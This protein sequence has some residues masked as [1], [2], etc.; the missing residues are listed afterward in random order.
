M[1]SALFTMR[2]YDLI[3][4]A[5]ERRETLGYLTDLLEEMEE[6]QLA[7]EKKIKLAHKAEKLAKKAAKKIR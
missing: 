3:Q 6:A 4:Q 5:L 7:E 1:V 2:Q